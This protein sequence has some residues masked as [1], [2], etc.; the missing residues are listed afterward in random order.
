MKP[1]ENKT[2]TPKAMQLGENPNFYLIYLLFYFFPWIFRSPT[3]NDVIAAVV[4]IAVFL[5]IYLKG[6][7]QTGLLR[8]IH[9]AGLLLIS[10]A[11]SPF[12]A[13]TAYF[14]YTPWR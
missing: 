7:T 6:A 3:T 14:L 10:F 11:V 4:A 8:L 2:P 13:H 5:P 1:L 12:L 9:I